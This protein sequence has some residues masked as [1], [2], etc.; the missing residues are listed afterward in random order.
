MVV[1]TMCIFQWGLFLLLPLCFLGRCPC[2]EN[3]WIAR[4]ILGGSLRVRRCSIC[5]DHLLLL[6]SHMVILRVFSQVHQ[7]L[8]RHGLIE[9]SNSNRCIPLH[10]RHPLTSSQSN[11]SNRN[12]EEPHHSTTESYY[13]HPPSKTPVQPSTLH[14]AEHSSPINSNPGAMILAQDPPAR[15]HP[16]PYNSMLIWGSTQPA[17]YNNTLR[18]SHHR[19]RVNKD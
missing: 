17:P 15:T 18:C 10:P 4:G 12:P 11:T 8:I 3:N 2:L 7:R 14:L 6:L 5:L 19:V 13:P 16:A 9:V 1:G